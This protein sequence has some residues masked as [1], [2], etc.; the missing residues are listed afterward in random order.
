MKTFKKGAKTSELWVAIT[1][2]LSGVGYLIWNEVQARCQFDSAFLIMVGGIV[3]SYIV[4]RSYL[5]AKK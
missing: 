4:G 1:G 5:K 3:V 2:L